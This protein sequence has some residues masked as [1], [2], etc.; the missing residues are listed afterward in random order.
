M[1]VDRSPVLEPVA[2]AGGA[3]VH[4]PGFVSGVREHAAGAMRVGVIGYG[5]WG[6]NIVR[7]FQALDN[8][9]LVTLCDKSPDALRRAHRV[10]PGLNLTTDFNDILKSP[11]IDVVAVVTPVWTHYDLA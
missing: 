7:N 4:T 11:D 9:E 10:Y 8:C 2:P 1:S 6:P 5:Y 3:L